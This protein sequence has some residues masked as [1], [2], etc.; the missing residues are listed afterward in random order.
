M[1]KLHFAAGAGLLALAA[2]SSVAIPGLSPPDRPACQTAD[3][4][5]YFAPDSATL[6]EEAAPIIRQ[7]LSALEACR[8][9]GGDLV[10]A[11]VRA[12]PDEAQTGSEAERAALARAS[13][14]VGALRDAGLTQDQV[15]ALDHRTPDNDITAIMRRQAQIRFEMR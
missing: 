13:A 15:V 7:A 5:I 3:F 4:S 11:T 2:C 9:Q 6:P 14:V 8:A 12:Y 10:R 1:K